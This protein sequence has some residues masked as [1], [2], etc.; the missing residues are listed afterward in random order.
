MFSVLSEA[1]G[2]QARACLKWPPSW[3]GRERGPISRGHV[4][5]PDGGAGAGT[6]KEGRHLLCVQGM[7]KGQE[8]RASEAA[9]PNPRSL[10]LSMSPYPPPH[11]L[12]RPGAWSTPT[13]LPRSHTWLRTQSLLLDGQGADTLS[14][15][16]SL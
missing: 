1:G 15:L 7:K 13:P 16:L 5:N 9:H 3:P 4:W 12:L 2:I 14:C 10:Y 11:Q 6:F 8:S